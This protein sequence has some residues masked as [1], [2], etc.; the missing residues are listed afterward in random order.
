M[1]R[2]EVSPSTRLYPPFAARCRRLTVACRAVERHLNLAL[3]GQLQIGGL[4]NPTVSESPSPPPERAI[5]GV[6]GEGAPLVVLGLLAF[7]GVGGG[8]LF[9]FGVDGGAPVVG[10]VAAMGAFVFGLVALG[11]LLR[12][13]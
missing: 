13:W 4:R 8:L 9:K 5:D 12:R 2:P 10:V 7:S 6:F 1:G 11:L 3:L